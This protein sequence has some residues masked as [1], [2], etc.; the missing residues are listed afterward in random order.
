MFCVCRVK[1]EGEIRRL[2]NSRLHRGEPHRSVAFCLLS[3]ES[4]W[5]ERSGARKD[6]IDFEACLSSASR[7]VSKHCW[8]LLPGCR[9]TALSPK[10]GRSFGPFDVM[11]SEGFSP[12]EAVVGL[13]RCTCGTSPPPRASR[14]QNQLC[15]GRVRRPQTRPLAAGLGSD[16]FGQGTEKGEVS[17]VAMMGTWSSLVV[18]EFRDLSCKRGASVC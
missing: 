11:G 9:L 15:G 14:Q 6:K 3:R 4:V 8:G 18:S 16:R 10:R 12:E 7:R 17:R 1:V 5:A 2:R 13:S